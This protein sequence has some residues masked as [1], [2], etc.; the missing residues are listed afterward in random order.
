MNALLKSGKYLLAIPMILFGVFHFMGAENMKN[1]VPSYLPASI[2]W[3]YLTGAA[4]I[5]AGVSIVIGKKDKLAAT[6]LGI[7]M[8]AFVLLMHLPASISGQDQ[9]AQVM[10]L[11]DLVMAGGA[12]LYA[13]H[14]AKD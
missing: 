11:K 14:A 9:M 6:L 8:L 1:M 7:M 2:F 13:A 4:L 10:M 3:V 12:F 5:A